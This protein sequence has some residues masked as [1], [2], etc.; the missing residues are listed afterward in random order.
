MRASKIH[1]VLMYITEACAMVLIVLWAKFQRVELL[2]FLLMMLTIT[3]TEHI[4]YLL[5]HIYEML[6]RK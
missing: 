4:L 5:S 1:L 6:N 2:L 3:C